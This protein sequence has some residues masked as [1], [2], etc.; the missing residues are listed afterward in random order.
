M[1]II[2][3]CLFFLAATTVRAIDPPPPPLPVPWECK[4]CPP[5]Q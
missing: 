1:T 5:G 3:F 2:R 4:I